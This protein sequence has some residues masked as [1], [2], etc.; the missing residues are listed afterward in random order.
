MKTR[1]RYLASWVEFTQPSL[2]LLTECRRFLSSPCMTRRRAL[3]HREEQVEKYGG[4]ADASVVVV[5]VVV[6]DFL[7]ATDDQG[8]QKRTN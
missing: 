5:I 4:G 2:H 6:A 8:V 3:G 1:L 7:G